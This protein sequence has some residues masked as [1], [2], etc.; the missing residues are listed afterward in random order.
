MN[1]LAPS[2]SSVIPALAAPVASPQA[3]ITWMSL[4]DTQI[5]SSTPLARRASMLRM[6][7]GIWAEWQVGVKAPGTAK[8]TT[9][10]PL[11]RSATLICS[12]PVSPSRLKDASG[13]LSPTEMV[14]WNS[15]GYMTDN[16]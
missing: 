6:K 13:S 16:R 11:V 5:T 9:L 12:S 7:L 1:T 3:R 15:P 10:R 8:I 2:D 4:T 14:M